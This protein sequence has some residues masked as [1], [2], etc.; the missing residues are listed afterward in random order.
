MNFISFTFAFIL[1]EVQAEATELDVLEFDSIQPLRSELNP[2]SIQPLR[3]EQVSLE[4][5]DIES[6]RLMNQ[7]TILPSKKSDIR[8]SS[9]PYYTGRDSGPG[10]KSSVLKYLLQDPEFGKSR[11]RIKVA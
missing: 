3:T 7:T 5:C 2:S 9:K 11:G 4:G 1:Q 10:E 6:G 8:C